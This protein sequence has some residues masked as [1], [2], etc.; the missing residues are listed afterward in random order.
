MNEEMIGMSYTYFF[1][2]FPGFLTTHLIQELFKEE[3]TIGHVYLLHE[4]SMQ[5]QAENQC[6]LLSHTTDVD[7]E[8]ITL[9]EGDITKTDLGID[10]QISKQVQSEVTHFFHLAAIYDLAV[11]LPLAWKVNVD[12]TRN[13]TNW[14]DQC[15][16]LTRYI[17]F[18]TAYVSGKREGRIMETELEHS[19]GFKNHYEYTKYEAE[20]IVDRHKSHLPTTIIRPGI[21][22]G[23]S[24]SGETAKFDGPY[25]ILNM[26]DRLRHS[27][28]LP[29]F[30]KGEA[31]VNLVP[32][33]Y[34]LRATIH[35]A[36][37]KIAEGR[38]YHVTDP[39]PLRAKEIYERF[40]HYYLQKKPAGT[41]PISIAH[42]ALR[43]P[44]TRRWLGIQRQ[45]L[46]YFLCNSQFDSSLA[47]QDLRLNCPSFDQ[48]CPS[49]VHYYH[50]HKDDR[51]KHVSML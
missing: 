24:Q 13:V 48:Y 42:Q 36:H 19:S 5:R 11:P 33:D 7:P 18:S 30:G 2:G 32:L 41:L 45:A 44:F 4:P 10:E 26:M 12:G 38:T 9:V 21:V 50:D 51:T 31:Y 27:P 23:H 1:T 47:Q 28:V 8:K 43:V 3:H 6:L 49:L 46:D 14:L 39:S 29:F 35:A 22:V 15:E 37:S 20:K 40:S 25:F 17:Y 34:L 16:Q